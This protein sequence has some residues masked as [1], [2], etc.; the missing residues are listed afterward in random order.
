MPCFGSHHRWTTTNGMTASIRKPIAQTRPSAAE[1]ARTSP[2]NTTT[3]RARRHF[4]VLSSKCPKK[5]LPKA[6]IV[7]T[8]A[9][10]NH[11]GGPFHLSARLLWVHSRALA[12]YAL[13]L[14]VAHHPDV[15]IAQRQLGLLPLLDAN[16]MQSEPDHGRVAVDRHRELV[17]NGRLHLLIELSRERQLLGLVAAA[18][19]VVRGDELVGEHVPDEG[20]VLAIERLVPIPLERNENL[21]SRSDRGP[22]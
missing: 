9:T 13:P 5:M 18:A 2:T 20:D 12:R 16:H 22:L 11:I 17:L 4:G 7:M 21:L 10:S 8:I 14:A 3:F 19:I 15:G 1:I 6:K